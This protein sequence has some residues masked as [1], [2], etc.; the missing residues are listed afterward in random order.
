MQVLIVDDS[1][2]MRTF[3]A[4]TLKMTGIEASVHE[5]EN[6]K[7]AMNLAAEFMPDLILTDLNMPEMSGDELVTRI[8]NHP[9]LKNTPVLVLS[10]D[11]SA[12]RP[13]ELMHAG[14]T[15]YMT[16]PLSPESLR[17]GLL[18]VMEGKPFV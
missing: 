4:R 18:A 3:L 8:R 16:K 17:A 6:G 13:L 5:A 15:A 12:V 11:R 14:A 10:A 9:E 1:P 2:V 7:Q